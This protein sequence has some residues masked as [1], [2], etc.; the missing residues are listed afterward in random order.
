MDEGSVDIGGIVERSPI[1]DQEKWPCVCC[2]VRGLSTE[3][4]M[5][6][7]GPCG[8][9]FPLGIIRLCPRCYHLHP[10]LIGWC[11][12]YLAV[13]G[14]QLPAL[15]EWLAKETEPTFDMQRHVLRQHGITDAEPVEPY[16]PSKIVVPIGV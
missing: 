15:E 10:G 5:T 2:G 13:N 3:R 12:W 9:R 16:K 11:A 4:V 8:L 1:S 14:R 6:C 7:S